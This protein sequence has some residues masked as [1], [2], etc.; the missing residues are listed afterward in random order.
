MRARWEYAELRWAA[1]IALSKDKHVWK[2]S[3]SLRV[4][5]VQVAEWSSLDTDDAVPGANNPPEYQT[6]HVMVM[7][8]QQGWELMTFEEG[9][10]AVDTLKLGTWQTTG[11]HVVSATWRF[12][13]PLEG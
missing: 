8:G 3:S 13:R 2:S 11:S 5:D 10:R 7:M 6:G 9:T 1:E 12:K 4:N